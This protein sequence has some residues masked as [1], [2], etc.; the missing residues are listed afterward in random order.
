[1]AMTSTL[2]QSVKLSL[3]NVANLSRNLTYE[4]LWL[5]LMVTMMMIISESSCV[6]ECQL[7]N[8]KNK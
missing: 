6:T 4:T 8:D 3:V 2:F 1:M 5:R 7:V